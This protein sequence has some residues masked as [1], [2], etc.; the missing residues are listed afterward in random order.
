[1]DALHHWDADRRGEM[2][3]G[4]AGL[5]HL[6]LINTPE[7]K[8]EKLPCRDQQTGLIITADARIDNRVELLDQLNLEQKK[9]DPVPDS[10][11]ILEAYKK[12]GTSCTDHLVGAFSFAVYEPTSRQL[13]CARDHMGFKPFYYLDHKKIFLFASEIKGIK[14]HPHAKLTANELF[15]LDALSALRSEKNQTFYNE[16]HRLPP[17]HQMVITPAEI[18]IKRYWELNPHYELVLQSEEDYIRTFR[19]KLEEAVR[20]RLRSNYPIGAE[21]SGGID[22]SAIVSLAAKEG[23]VKTFSHAL[24]E[25]AKDMHFPYKDETDHSKKV[26]EYHQIR[27]HF[28]IT[29]ENESLMKTLKKGLHL[30]EGMI[31]ITLSEMFDPLYR[32][33]QTENCR[34]LLSGY[35]GDEMVTSR[36]SGYLEELS[37]RFRFIKLLKELRLKNR[38]KGTLKTLKQFVKYLTYGQLGHF[39]PS[40]KVPNWANH[41]YY[42]LAIHPGFLKE[43]GLKKRFYQKNSLPVGG[44]T[45]IRQY[46]RIKFDNMPQRLEYCAIKAQ[47]RKIE[48]RYPLLD[49]RLIEFYLSLPS[50]MKA[51]KGYGRYIIRKSMEGILPPGIQW[52]TDKTGTVIPSIFMRLKQDEE[53]MRYLIEKARISPIK[54]YLDYDK[55]LIMLDRIA[56]YDENTKE[57]ITPQ[58]FENSLMLLMYQLEKVEKD[59]S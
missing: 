25:W 24:P 38:G 53:S 28:F 52:R 50:W 55:L 20:C 30:H 57:T 34:T 33:A 42:A 18:R 59:E 44:N 7:S 2:V 9:N 12:Y 29:G 3:E 21:L 11:V 36:A 27:D 23:P 48:Y 4:S 49:K 58:A 35:G 22:S 47:T 8:N 15:I 6:L 56:N 19:K 14:A 40:Y 32:K 10:Q 39:R 46:R 5:G 43:K 17:A 26:I 51:Q 31:Q 41:M 1:M 16:V 13:F 54:H 45:R 37:A